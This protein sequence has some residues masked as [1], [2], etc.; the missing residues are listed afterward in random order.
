MSKEYAIEL[1]TADSLLRRSNI[2]LHMYLAERGPTSLTASAVIYR[3]DLAA[4]HREDK[5]TRLRGI[6][7]WK[8]SLTV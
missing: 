2:F 8:M 6:I 5:R 4:L 7:G 3:S 1:R